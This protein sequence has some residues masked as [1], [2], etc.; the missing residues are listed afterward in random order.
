MR[1]LVPAVLALAL[2]ACGKDDSA[3][4]PAAKVFVESVPGAPVVTVDGNV[5]TEPLLSAYADRRK[6]D[7]KD[8]AQRQ[9][10]IDGLVDAMVLAQDAVTSNLMQDERVRAQLAHARI[11]QLATGN[12]DAFR[13]ASPIT[14]AQLKAFYDEE[15]ARTGGV[16]LQLQHIL[17]ADEASARSA[18]EVAKAPGADFDAIVAGY[19]T[20]ARQAKTLDWANLAQLPPELAQATKTLQDGEIAP[21]PVQTQYG[22][23]VVK[24]VASR[25]YTP[26]SMEQVRDGAKRQLEGQMLRER[27]K[28]LREKAK[29][30]LPGGTAAPPKG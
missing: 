8:P 9:R 2:A 13:N 1:L 22:W 28:A 16:E 25:P 12:I 11:E 30:V 18:L 23:H 20:T 24:R 15:A 26:P 27:I 29:V 14:D 21:Q 10:A 3:A 19:E 6:L 5:V 7:L 4:P 17:F